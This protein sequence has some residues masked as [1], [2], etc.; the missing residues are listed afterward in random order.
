M[1][2]DGIAFMVS[3]PHCLAAALSSPIVMQ[4]VLLHPSPVL[5][6]TELFLSASSLPPSE[7]CTARMP[8]R[9]LHMVSFLQAGTKVGSHSLGVR[10]GVYRCALRGLL[11]AVQDPQMKAALQKCQGAAALQVGACAESLLYFSNGWSG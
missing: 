10:K 8:E 3:C 7:Q 5:I 1:I 11:A 6:R 2:P 4:N 9:W